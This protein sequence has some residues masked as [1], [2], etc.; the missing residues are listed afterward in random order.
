MLTAQDRLDINETLA[1]PAYIFDTNL[2][3]T[4]TGDD[5]AT[6][7]SR[8]RDGLWRISRRVITPIDVPTTTEAGS[9]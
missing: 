4:S 8:R 2:L 3:A 9:R 6:V 5:A 7:Q 1:L